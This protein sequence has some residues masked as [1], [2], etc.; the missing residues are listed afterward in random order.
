MVRWLRAVGLP[1]CVAL[2]VVLAALP[3]AR[4][5]R[6][7]LLAQLLL[8]AALTPAVVSAAMRRLPAATVAPVSVL[9]LAAYTL[10]AVRV[11]AHS[12][13][14]P[15]SVSTLWTD[16]LRN[17]IPRVLTALIPVEPQP[18]TILAPVVATWLAALAAA[19]LAVRAGRVLLGCA[20][21]ALLYAGTLVVVGPNARPALWQPVVFAATAAVALAL[22][23]RPDTDRLPD[24]PR[25]AALTI[26][27]RLA[28]GA[29]AA[30]ATIVALA[31]AI[32]P[33]LA[34]RVT[35]TPSDPRQY[36]SPPRLDNSDE[37]PLIRLS[38]W[39]LNP[40]EPLLTTDITG[41]S[42]ESSLRIRLAVL[43]DYDGVNWRV[44][45]DYREA[46]RVLPA[47]AGTGTVVTQTITVD[48]LGG[49]LLPA[50]SQV[51]RVDGVRV[52]YDEATGT[53]IRPEGLTSGLSYTVDSQSSTVDGNL[54]PAADIPSGPT[55]KRFL[56]LGASAPADLTTLATQIAGNEAGPYQ[57]AQALESFLAGHYTYVTDAPSGHAYPNLEFF[58]LA[59]RDL[60]G[61]RGTSEQ[62]A[63]AFAVLGRILGLPT[64]VVV[65]FTA[66]PGHSTVDGKDALAWPEVLF[67]GLGWVPF[68]PLPQANSTPQPLTSD[69]HPQ[70]ST[71]TPPPSAAPTIAIS[72][73]PPAPSH[74]GS[75]AVHKG[76]SGPSAGQVTGIG[77]GVL[78]LF[79]ALLV[80]AG[81]R[82][83]TQLA[84]RLSRGSPGHRVLGAWAE[85]LDALR[86]AGRSTSADQTVTEVA[87]HAGNVAT[88]AGRTRLPVPPL[89]DLASL[90]N[91]VGY[92]PE[93]A[94]EDDA[95]RAT[96]QATAYVTELRARQPRWR[97]LRW[98]L[99]QSLPLLV[100]RPE[101]QARHR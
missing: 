27:V 22:T 1:V 81:L 66:K 92:A 40:N 17:G 86:L 34:G 47:V 46:G 60:G 64:R 7:D 85:V 94:D 3:L 6:G 52:A 26:R 80:A 30:L 56:A 25:A 58:L 98:V 21:P 42:P 70:P 78:I 57:R 54:L 79:A 95:H 50:V 73:S 29:C 44:D 35:A 71:S 59:A 37:N 10:Y 36:V 84:D 12:A 74:S 72:A 68:N 39:A 100:R 89:D 5:Y 13:G 63:A 48:D 82:R 83:R 14:I 16:A 88:A 99:R 97:R 19:E 4:I 45:G 18:D 67:T 91:L 24:L 75:T 43:S 65:G 55:V 53:L 69:I 41:N 31:A 62:F 15:G 20:P 51:K 61:Q 93:D 9:L 23:G 8:V 11:S 90:V 96:T 87:T 101:R 38:G 2:L 49:R 32:G 33:A 76:L 28:I 77:G